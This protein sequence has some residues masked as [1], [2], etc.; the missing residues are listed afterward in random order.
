VKV[1]RGRAA[2]T[3]H[4][5]PNATPERVEG[6]EEATPEAR[7]RDGGPQI[8]P[9]WITSTRFP[10]DMG[11]RNIMKTHHV[12]RAFS[13]ALLLSPAVSLQA[14]PTSATITG[15]NPGSISNSNMADPAWG[16]QNTANS[17]RDWPHDT[18]GFMGMV[19]PISLT[20]D[21]F[22][23]PY[24]SGG[25]D[26]SI[27][28]VGGGGHIEFRLDN[29]VAALDGGKEIG[30]FVAQK[31]LT[32]NGNLF[33]GDYRGT[34]SVS[35]DGSNWTVIAK[36]TSLNAPTFAYDYETMAKAWGYGSGTSQANLDALSTAD[37]TTPMPDAGDALFNPAVANANSSAIYGLRNSTDTAAYDN[38]LGGSGGGNW[39]SFSESGLDWVEYIRVDQTSGDIRFDAVFANA[40]AVPEASTALICLFGTVGLVVHLR[41][42]RRD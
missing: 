30:I 5:F 27:V 31:V 32:T 25:N 6:G 41:R 19:A 2:V 37:F 40:S 1:G 3:G 12:L 17:M 7:R 22:M 23:N 4:D 35:K 29:R 28:T 36:N 42:K 21:N 24:W 13:V 15:Y 34:V 39:F 8:R 14:V 9:E 26:N 16:Y 33:N 38:L 11:K 10:R 18:G 20:N